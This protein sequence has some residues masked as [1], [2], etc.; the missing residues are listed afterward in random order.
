[1]YFHLMQNVFD[2]QPTSISF[3]Y[4]TSS[5]DV[6]HVNINHRY[7]LLSFTHNE[8]KLNKYNYIIDHYDDTVLKHNM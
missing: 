7:E 8:L 4:Q 2:S 6:S 1:M 3:K 5:A